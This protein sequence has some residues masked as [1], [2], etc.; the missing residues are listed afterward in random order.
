MINLNTSI[1]RAGKTNL[2]TS[3]EHISF[4]KKWK[5]DLYIS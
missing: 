2:I 1:E 3:L 4:K 5:D